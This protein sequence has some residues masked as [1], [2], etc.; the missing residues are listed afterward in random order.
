MSEDRERKIII[1]HGRFGE[2]EDFLN[3]LFRPH[4]PNQIAAF[5]G[6]LDVLGQASRREPF[7]IRFEDVK[8]ERGPSLDE[9]ILALSGELDQLKQ[10]FNK[11]LNVESRDESIE[12]FKE[13]ISHVEEISKVY[14][15]HKADKVVFWI[16]YDKGERIDILE[17]VVDIECA[18]ER[19]FRRLDFAYRVLPSS[20]LSSRIMS[21]ADVIYSRQK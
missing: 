14:V 19:V 20:L 11:Y 13:L 18:F 15:Q 17:R 5:R 4:D 3:R 12:Q 9:K 7:T 8:E 21:R 1:A 6:F 2:A 10:Q 16:F